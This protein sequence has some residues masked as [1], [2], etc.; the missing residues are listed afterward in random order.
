MFGDGFVSPWLDCELLATC[1]RLTRG[2]SAGS[3][4]SLS[5]DFEAAAISVASSGRSSRRFDRRLLVRLDS[6]GTGVG[7]GLA[8]D[9]ATGRG[10]CSKSAGGVGTAKGGA[11]VGASEPLLEGWRAKTD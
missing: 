7:I 3:V 8:A 9:V 4:V 1:F 11:G 6:V 2:T 5:L 10:S